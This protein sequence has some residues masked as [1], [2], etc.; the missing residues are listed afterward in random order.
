VDYLAGNHKVAR[1]ATARTHKLEELFGLVERSDG[2]RH[3]VRVSGGIQLRAEVRLMNGGDVTPLRGVVLKSRPS[4]AALTWRIPVEGW[5]MPN[6]K[7]LIPPRPGGLE[8]GALG[9]PNAGCSLSFQSVILNPT[10]LAAGDNSRQRFAGFPS[11]PAPP[12]LNGVSFEMLI[13]DDSFVRD[14]T[15]ELRLLRTTF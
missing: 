8:P 15:G 2:L 9:A 7:D 13:T 5:E 11:V 3:L 14:K 10:R 12:Q 6:A 4:P 1:V